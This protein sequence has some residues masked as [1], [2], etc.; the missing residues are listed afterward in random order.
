MSLNHID[1]LANNLNL[2]PYQRQVLKSNRDEYDMTGLVMRGG[3]LYAPRRR[4]KGMF[5]RAR[6]M[7]SGRSADLIGRNKTLLCDVR[8]IRFYAGGYYSVPVNNDVFYAD[9]TGR[10]I[11]RDVFKQALKQRQF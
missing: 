3:A 1:A 5:S 2:T 11:S 9:A 7:L 8:G 6:D 4:K 10:I